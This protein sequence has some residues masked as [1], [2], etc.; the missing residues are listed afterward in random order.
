[1]E[2]LARKKKLI[3]SLYPGAK[4]QLKNFPVYV[5]PYS[6]NDIAKAMSKVSKMRKTYDYNKLKKFLKFKNSNYYTKKLIS[7]LLK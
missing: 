3:N 2:A 5:N 7:Y 6:P 1:M 4:E